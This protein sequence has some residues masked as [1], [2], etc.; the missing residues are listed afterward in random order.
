M[1]ALLK[2]FS[3][4]AKEFKNLKSIVTAALLLALHTILSLFLSIYVTDSLRISISFVTNVVT[5]AFFGPVMG[6]ACGGLGDL[7]SFIVKPTGPYFF[8]WTLS[9]ALAGFVYGL[10]FHGHFP[11]NF[12]MNDK[13]NA[14]N[15]LDAKVHEGNLIVRILGFILPV[16]GILIWAI[17]PFVHVS[18]KKSGE[19]LLS[20]TAFNALTGFSVSRN[21]A[22]LAG[23]LLAVCIF[24]FIMNIFNRHTIP[25]I[26]TILCSFAV[27]LA[28]YTD[29]KTT[30]PQ[31]GYWAIMAVMVAY[32]IIQLVYLARRHSVDIAFLVRCSIA[33][34]VVNVGVNA[35]LGTYWL[36]MMYGKGF[37]FYFTSR[38]IKNLVQLPIN[39]VLAYYV[40]GIVGKMRKHLK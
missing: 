39:I 10:L 37:A 21:S 36:S 24:V 35:L 1:N 7:L 32:I 19:V 23:I 16:A 13:E 26:I 2:S 40:L 29:K 15:Q 3:D 18:D 34:I 33:M 25:L 6:L 5:G 31:T 22:I 20:G 4:S 9:A 17:A 38:L 14:S 8:G 30:Q 11:R 27:E 12:A 28:V